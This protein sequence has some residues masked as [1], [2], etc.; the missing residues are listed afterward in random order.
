MYKKLFIVFSLIC[1]C[2]FSLILTAC[3]ENKYSINLSKSYSA[4]GFEIQTT[5]D[6]SMADSI[7]SGIILTSNGDL[8][9]N[10]DESTITC[11]YDCGNQYYN[12]SNLSLEQYIEDIK[13]IE[14]LD[15]ASSTTTQINET[16][17]NTTKGIELKV[18]VVD[19]NSNP[20]GNWDYYHIYYFG[21]AQNSFLYFKISTSIQDEYYQ[22]NIEKYNAIT[23]SITFTQPD[24]ISDYDSSIEAYINKTT[25]STGEIF[26]NF[27]FT[28]TVPTN[29]EGSE[30]IGGNLNNYIT[31][32]YDNN[33]W[34]SGIYAKTLSTFMGGA[35]LNDEGA[36]H[37]LKYPANN[38]LGF[39]T[40]EINEENTGDFISYVYNVYFLNNNNLNKNY[41]NIYLSCSQELFTA[42]FVN[43]FEEQLFLWIEIS[44]AN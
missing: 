25:W 29:Y 40:K 26:S 35:S 12:I 16:L 11:Q 6:F 8:E 28:L 2:C 23:S 20:T 1:I 33:G 30:N 7:S 4:N 15:L 19:E 27:G 42:G 10:F 13:T 36:K 24:F 31:T 18:Y 9:I 34:E 22:Q 5:K 17:G 44:S 3:K 32:S 37:L 43:Y 14:N 39:Y 41:L 38:S 21:K